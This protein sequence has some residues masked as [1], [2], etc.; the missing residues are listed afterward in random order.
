MD[1]ATD[2][3]R[4]RRLSGTLTLERVG[5]QMRCGN[6]F[7]LRHLAEEL[8][9]ECDRLSIS[10]RSLFDLSHERKR[11]RQ[12]ELALSVATFDLDCPTEVSDC[13]W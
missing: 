2:V 8:G 10:N 13:Y 5:R 11:N 3:T 9:I 12:F 7:L 1:L 6:K 4:L